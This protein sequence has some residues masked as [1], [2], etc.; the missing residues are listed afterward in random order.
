M[1]STSAATAVANDDARISSNDI[2]NN[3]GSSS[4]SSANAGWPQP[5]PPPSPRS[6]AEKATGAGELVVTNN[7]WQQ[8]QGVAE[9]ES[10]GNP[11]AVAAAA[12]YNYGGDL[13]C[14]SN[15][16]IVGGDKKMIL[17]STNGNNTRS[18]VHDAAI[19][20]NDVANSTT[21]LPFTSSS[22]AGT[23]GG[24]GEVGLL[25][26]S[27]R[28][29]DYDDNNNNQHLGDNFVG[30]SGIRRDYDE[31]DYDGMEDYLEGRRRGGE[32]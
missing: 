25:E 23:M 19:T 28:D 30:G 13:G 20:G 16:A 26:L 32:E 18:L 27:H 11:T 24:G 12:G 15:A 3:N 7:A 9:V 10:G 4:S 1:T 29:D 21:I 2:Y 31:D 5:Q 14:S 22:W 17:T 6:A 8:N